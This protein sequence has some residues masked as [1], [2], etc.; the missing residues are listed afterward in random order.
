MASVGKARFSELKTYVWTAI[1]FVMGWVCTKALDTYFNTTLLSSLWSWLL[2]VWRDLK[3][4]IS[5]PV[6]TVFA[7][8][9]CITAAS[10]VAIYYYIE[11]R[12]AYKLLEEVERLA[13]ETKTAAPRLSDTQ[14]KIMWCFAYWSN[15]NLRF[16]DSTLITYTG[17]SRLE[18]EVGT[19]QLA[20]LGLLQWATYNTVTGGQYLRLTLKGKE[21]AL[22]IYSKNPNMGA[23]KLP[24]PKIADLS[25]QSDK[26]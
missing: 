10:G 26:L 17:L 8:T 24:K 5:V 7:V 23:P 6:W 12:K 19:G 3:Q 18:L 21:I 25:R 1:T 9:L 20:S 16:D 4:G 14:T 15:N 11:A 2:L 13:S 22:S